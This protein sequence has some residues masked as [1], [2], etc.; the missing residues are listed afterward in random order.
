[1]SDKKINHFE[2]AV[3]GGGPGGYV[4]AIKAAQLGKKVCIIEKNKIGGTCLNAGC[5][6]TKALLRSVE[7]YKQ[8]K[9]CKKYGIEGIKQEDIKIN[10]SKVQKRKK[11]VVKQLIRGVEI[12]LKGN[13]VKIINK[14]AKLHDK[15]T[16]QVGNQVIKADN[17]IIATGSVAKML[18]VTISEKAEVLTS[19]EALDL[20]NKPESI[21]IIG[22]GVI[23]VEFAYFLASIG[24]KVSIVECLDRILPMIDKEITNQVTKH[25]LDIKIDIHTSARV[26]EINDKS[27]VYKKY[28]EEYE[29]LTE[30]VL[31]AVG[32]IPNTNGLNIESLGIKTNRGAI[33]TDK[34]LRTNIDNIYAI[35]DVNAKAMFAH[36]ASMEGI[37]A[38]E[39]ICGHKKVMEYDKIPSAI[40]IQPEIAS[41]GLT[42]EEAKKKYKEIKV[43]K[44]PL[45][46]NGKAKVAGEERGFIK[47]ITE[48]NFSKILGVHIYGIHA[49]DMISEAVVAMNLESTA[50]EV[51]MSIH[52]HPTVSEIMNEAFHAV[53]DKA[54]HFL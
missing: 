20:D 18:P 49:T 33:I 13:G 22:G 15:N 16:I 10:M 51:A 46:A 2:I 9:E 4:A 40:Y 27:V 19:K 54:I 29:I 6:P 52:P 28:G 32:R 12:L 25:L 45:V 14:E 43:G 41:V 30:K 1:M 50:E 36:T 26:T 44:F 23:G 47:V 11:K 53:T 17:I 48:P 21:V 3:I 42:E 39:N 8:V 24:V 35:G 34:Y 37:I 38:I 5:I 7:A 31:M